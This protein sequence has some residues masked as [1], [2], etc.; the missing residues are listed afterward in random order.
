MS[1]KKIQRKRGGKKDADKKEGVEEAEEQKVLDDE[2]AGS[3][4]VEKPA[5]AVSANAGEEVKP[6]EVLEKEKV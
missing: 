1:W 5:T 3:G 2:E 4:G 6:V